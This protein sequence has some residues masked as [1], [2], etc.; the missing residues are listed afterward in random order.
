M[1]SLKQT[2]AK[3]HKSLDKPAQERFAWMVRTAVD[4]SAKNTS[5]HAS[6]DLAELQLYELAE[7]AKGA[8]NVKTS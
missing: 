5:N 6:K 2:Y 3:L 8:S 7:K 4:M 1:P